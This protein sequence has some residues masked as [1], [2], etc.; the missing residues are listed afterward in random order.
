MSITTVVIT[1]LTDGVDVVRAAA[2]VE[3]VIN[4]MLEVELEFT[5][6]TDD[7]VLTPSADDVVLISLEEVDLTITGVLIVFDS[8]V[9]VI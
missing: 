8:V 6:G 9:F 7:V 3:L 5:K 4:P 2:G 1:S